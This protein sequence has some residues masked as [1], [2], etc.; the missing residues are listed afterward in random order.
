MAFLGENLKKIRQEHKLTQIELANM[1]GISQKSYSHWETQ[2]TEPTLENVVKLANIFNTT[3][4]YFLGQTIYSKANLV[5]FLDDYDVSNIKNWTKEERDSFK[6]AIIFEVISKNDMVGLFKLRDD[7]VTKN[8]LDEEEQEIMNTLF[9][10]VFDYF[11]T[12]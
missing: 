7:L 10:E 6:F 8:H 12:D 11:N 3:T 2:K 9:K 4:D 1:L 5:R